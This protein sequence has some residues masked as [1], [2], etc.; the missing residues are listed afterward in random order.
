MVQEKNVARFNADVN[1]KKGYL[2]TRGSLSGRLS[3]GRISEEVA[4]L[5]EFRK[6]RVLDI[7]SGDGTYTAELVGF[8]AAAV[9]GADAAAAAVKAAAKRHKRRGLRFQVLDVYKAK[10]PAKPYDVM[11]VRGLLH[12]LYDPA[13]AV[14]ALGP[15]ARTAIIVE[16][17]GWNPVLKLIEKLSPYHREHE[18]RSYLPPRLDRWFEA[19]GGRVVERRYIGLVPFFCPDWAAH[20]L[21]ALEPLV[22]STPLLR[23]L[24]CAQYVFKVEFGKPAAPK[25]LRPAKGRKGAA[26]VAPSPSWGP[27]LVAG[28]VGLGLCALGVAVFMKSQFIGTSCIVL[29]ASLAFLQWG[30]GD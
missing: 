14:K 4:S 9:I 3:N 27:G 17:N 26:A 25:A 13:R 6:S 24:G 10:K 19:A 18:E 16:P 5:G 30:S 21:K 2:Y 1:A 8:G 23:E 12:H 11:V 20:L 22:E 7:G 15:Q 28:L 29:G